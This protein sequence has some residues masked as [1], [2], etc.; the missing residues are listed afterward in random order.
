MPEETAPMADIERL[1]MVKEPDGEAALED[2]PVQPI[3]AMTAEADL[4]AA[5]IIALVERAQQGNHTAFEELITPFQRPVQLYLAQL[6]G[7]DDWARDL[8]Q[9][10]FWQ[11]WRGLPK[12]REPALFRVWLFRIATNRAR[13]WLRHRRL[14]SWMSL[15]WLTGAKEE[16]DPKPSGAPNLIERLH[17]PETGFEEHLI[18]TET[19]KLAL[20]QVPR[21]YRACLL[22]H[23]SLGFTVPEVAEQL[24]LTRG[25]V[26]M[27]LF[28]GLAALRTA[29]QQQNEA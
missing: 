15:D 1:L 2:E 19:L 25:A 17:T 5:R 29:Y 14:I 7:D 28:R 10:T 24:G 23:L 9:D 12:L 22:L 16:G 4:E 18:E 8:A 11:A 3:G 27:R 21:D 13:S 6:I 26:R 20:A